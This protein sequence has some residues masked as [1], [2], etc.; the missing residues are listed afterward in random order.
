M[1]TEIAIIRFTSLGRKSSCFA[2]KL[3]LF[4]QLYLS[5]QNYLSSAMNRHLSGWKNGERIRNI[6]HDRI[7]AN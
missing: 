5:L 3:F 1:G 7:V 6:T 2:F 4:E